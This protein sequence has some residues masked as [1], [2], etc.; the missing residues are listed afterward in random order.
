MSHVV[1]RYLIEYTETQFTDSPQ[2]LWKGIICSVLVGV[3]YI[4]VG[5]LI[6]VNYF[7]NAKSRVR[8]GSSLTL[9]IYKKV[10]F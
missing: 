1:D 2:P 7:V 6:N 8:I 4:L 5:L 9:A 10:R 3:V